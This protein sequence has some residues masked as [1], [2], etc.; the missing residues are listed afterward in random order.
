MKTKFGENEI[1]SFWYW[2][3]L[4]NGKNRFKHL[5]TMRNFG[6]NKICQQFQLNSQ[7]SF[8]EQHIM[9]QRQIFNRIS[10]NTASPWPNFKNYFRQLQTTI[11]N[12]IHILLSLR[13]ETETSCQK[14]KLLCESVQIW[15]KN[16]AFFYFLQINKY[17]YQIIYFKN[18]HIFHLSIIFFSN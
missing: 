4:E 7:K 13:V 8:W 11:K 10:V 18:F 3:R 9:I 1:F 5:K 17:F 16:I 6:E 12:C 15:E 2:K 14:Q